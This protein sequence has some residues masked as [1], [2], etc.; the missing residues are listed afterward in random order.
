[1]SRCED[2]QRQLSALVDGLL[3]PGEDAAVRA[4]LRT[5]ADCSGVLEDI[6]RIVATAK[7]LGPLAPPDHVWLEVAGRIRLDRGTPQTAP[8]LKTRRPSPM[9]QWAG[10]AAALVATTLGLYFF[11]Q[12]AE[13]PPQE[14]TSVSE[15]APQ[16]AA[17]EPGTMDAVTQRLDLA[18][19]FYE[20]AISELE[21]ADPEFAANV[22]TS[23]TSI[24]EAIEES[25]AAMIDDPQSEP[26]RDSLF[27]ALRRKI[28]VLQATATLI[29]EMRQ[30]D[31]AGAARAA[32]GLGKK[33]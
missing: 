9:W 23:L 32:E 25:R 20:Q 10:M 29:N 8:V 33:S 27:E 7:R 16:A 22:R 21:A 26:A 4:H 15:P 13:A 30:G 2:I 1:M 31:Q 5:C 18:D 6:Q 12:A 17:P 24:D 19:A 11:Q 3:P 28:S 14:A